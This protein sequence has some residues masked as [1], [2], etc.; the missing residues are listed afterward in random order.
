MG[1]S[2]PWIEKNTLVA[3]TIAD[4]QSPNEPPRLV[5]RC[6]LGNRAMR[7]DRCNDNLKKVSEATKLIHFGTRCNVKLRPARF[8]A[9]RVV[10][11]NLTTVIQQKLLKPRKGSL[12][13]QTN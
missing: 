7:Q 10:V 12:A 6:F 5:W 11:V 3:R 8:L 13:A 1:L 9:L 2:G 4:T